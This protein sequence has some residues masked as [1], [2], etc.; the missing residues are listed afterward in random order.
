AGDGYVAAV[1]LGAAVL[2][3][4]LC[5]GRGPLA[6]LLSGDLVTEL[7]RMSCSVFLLH[8]PVYR[9]L[10]QGSPGLAPLP[11]FLVGGA[12]TWFLSLLVH[13]LLVERLGRVR[14]GV[15]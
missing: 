13:H 6:R 9:L 15:V 7:G 5:A 1:V 8:L 11:L 12:V 4:V 3:A 14:G 10:R 2:T